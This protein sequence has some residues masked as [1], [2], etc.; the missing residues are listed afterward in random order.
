VNIGGLFE[1][2]NFTMTFFVRIHISH[3]I[4][5]MTFNYIITL[6]STDRE[7]RLSYICQ[8]TANVFVMDLKEWS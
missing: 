7:K 2:C 5:K 1:L 4:P 3:I 6:N 8:L